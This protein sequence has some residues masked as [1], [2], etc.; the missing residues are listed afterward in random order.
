VGKGSGWWKGVGAGALLVVS[1]GQYI[2]SW[3]HFV[4]RMRIE[5]AVDFLK[6]WMLLDFEAVEAECAQAGILWVAKAYFI[7]LYLFV[8]LIESGE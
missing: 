3:Q 2:V 5:N 8:H 1:P 4:H 6:H 7:N